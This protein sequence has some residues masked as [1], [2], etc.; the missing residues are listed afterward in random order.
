MDKQNKD[1]MLRINYLLVKQMERF[2]ESRQVECLIQIKGRIRGYN[3]PIFISKPI[4]VNGNSLCEKRIYN[5]Y[6]LS[7]IN[8]L[9]LIHSANTRYNRM[10][11]TH[12]IKVFEVGDKIIVY[13]FMKS[14]VFNV[15]L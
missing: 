15:D 6:K 4:F 8:E 12:N 11:I 5:G 13:H 1:F 10:D 3:K 7:A 14:G 2:F 9:R